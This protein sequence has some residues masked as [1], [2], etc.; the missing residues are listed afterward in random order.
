MVDRH[1][2][3]PEVVGEPPHTESVQALAVDQGNGGGDLPAVE[4]RRRTAPASFSGGPDG[5]SAMPALDATAYPALTAV[6]HFQ[7]DFGSAAEFDRLLDTVL[8]GIRDQAA[9]RRSET[10]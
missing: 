9:R 10:P 1:R 4:S 3:D 8:C 6:A 5:P 7:A 2:V